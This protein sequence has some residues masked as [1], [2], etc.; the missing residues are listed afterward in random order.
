MSKQKKRAEELRE[1]LN[2]FA[3][4]YYAQDSPSVDDSVY[5]GLMQELKS[6]E[7]K[8]PELITADSPTQR[9]GSAPLDKFEKVEHSSRMLSLNDVFGRRI[10]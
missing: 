5:D 6:I 2:R 9:V 10:S 8:Y 3:Y 4:E 1:L 7:D